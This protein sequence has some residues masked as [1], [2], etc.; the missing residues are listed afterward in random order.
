MSRTRQQE[1][2]I[3]VIWLAGTPIVYLLW[4]YHFGNAVV[5]AVWDI[6]VYLLAFCYVFAGLP[7]RNF[8]DRAMPTDVVRLGTDGMYE[9]DIVYRRGEFEGK[10]YR[11]SDIYPE[12]KNLVF[13]SLNRN[14]LIEKAQ[15]EIMGL[16]R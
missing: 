8:I 5:D 3:L 10:V 6:I 16:G 13:Y 7:I 4:D 9:L 1:L 12:P 2:L 11:R 14:E 15:N